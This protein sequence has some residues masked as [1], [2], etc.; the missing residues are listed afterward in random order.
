[1]AVARHA[2]R[3]LARGGRLAAYQALGSELSLA[4]LLRSKAA[5][6]RL[7]LPLV[8]ARGRRMRFAALADPRGHWRRNRYGIAEYHAPQACRAQ[9]LA[10]VLLPLVG[11]DRHGGRLGQGGG[12][13]DATFARRIRHPG[14]RRP[15]L[16][17][18]GFACQEVAA[19]P[20]AAHDVRLDYVLS[21]TGLRRCR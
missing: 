7:C 4:A 13:Y 19:L 10:V 6:A 20:R 18:V 11:F 1:M 3:L 2:R 5:A 21:E 9:D 12:Y 17:G 15:L 14:L 8:P 16:V